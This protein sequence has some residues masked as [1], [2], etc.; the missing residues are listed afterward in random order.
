[1]VKRRHVSQPKSKPGKRTL[2]QNFDPNL[3]FYSTIM[4]QM[5]KQKRKM[6]NSSH[7]II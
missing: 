1:M 7:F 6:N 2:N 4:M 5:N 3:S